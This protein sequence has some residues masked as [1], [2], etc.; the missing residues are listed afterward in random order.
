MIRNLDTSIQ[1]ICKAHWGAHY[2]LFYKSKEDLVELL[3][4]YFK[5]GLDNN[6][7]C[8]W[9]TTDTDVEKKAR[10]SLSKVMP[11]LNDSQIKKQMEF[12][13]CSEW[14]LRDG[15]FQYELV[16]KN[17]IDKLNYSINQH[18]EGIRVTGDLGWLD[19]SVWQSLMDYEMHLNDSIPRNR[20]VAICSYPLEKLSASKLIDVLRHHQVAIAK[21][22]GEWHV[23]ETFGAKKSPDLLRSAVSSIGVEL[24]KADALNLPVLYPD[25]CNGCSLCI[26]VCPG[27]L[28]YLWD[29]KV[30]VQK[31]GTCDW[32]AYCEAVCPTNAII[33]PLEIT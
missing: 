31:S 25:K 12:A 6:Q 20:F 33:C 3:T 23:F 4:Q 10:K 29:G 32:C 1:S 18:Y 16:S 26:S 8:M 24:Q 27:G 28:L 22:N 11:N 30:A 13:N 19:E 2:C 21:N 14:Y 17:W 15:F 7:F 5:Y 9:V